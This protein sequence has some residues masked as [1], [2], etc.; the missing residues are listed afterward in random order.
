MTTVVLIQ[1]PDPEDMIVLR[2]HAGKFGI[3]EKKTSLVR[4]DKLPP[5]DLAYSAA[6]L[7]KNGF[8]V[9]I[10]DSPTLDLEK[11]KIL[12]ET[13]NKNPDLIFVN[14]SGASVSND[15]DFAS[16]LKNKSGVET[17]ALTQV[18]SPED[19][20]RKKDIEIFVRGEVEYTILELCQ[21]YPDI[22]KINGV[23]FKRGDEFFYNPKRFLIKNMDEL[24]FPAFHLLPMGKYSHHMFK[25]KNFTTVQTSRGCPF[26]CIYCPYPI[27][28]G[29]IWR[30]KSPENV[31][32]ELK[33]LAEEYKVKSILF[34][35]Q[36]FNFFPKRTEKICDGII[37]EGIDITWRCEA[38]VELLSKKFMKKMK[39]AGCAGVHLGVESGDPVILNKI[40]KGGV[41]ETHIRKL[42]KV[43]SDAREIGLE[44][45]AF[46]MIG[47]PGETKKSISKTFDLARDIKA[48][49]AWFCSVV[50]YPGTKLYELAERKGWLLTRDIRNYTGRSVVMRTDCLTGEEI[51]KAVDAG[52]FM[53]SKDDARFWKTIFSLKGI[54]SAFLDPKKAL[55]FTLGRFTNKKNL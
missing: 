35:D 18:F 14:T 12:K 11:S 2:D 46:F 7:E 34:R 45:V 13:M 36:V 52:N 20:L 16:W 53:F 24:P 22:K 48:N 27:G 29:N 33:I 55:K 10:I 49:R 39:Q 1:P 4:Y 38:R 47:F 42:K 26:G 9:S 51:K 3:V 41:S 21:K 15:L 5:L 43:F 6:L 23:F 54:S 40:A 8:D 44:T 37:K 17:V 25:R 31:L 30:G 50:P 28:Y 32:N 19:V